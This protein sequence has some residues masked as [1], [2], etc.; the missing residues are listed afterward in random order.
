MD[1]CSFQEVLS[2]AVGPRSEEE[3]FTVQQ[4]ESLLDKVAQTLRCRKVPTG[5]PSF[6]LLIFYTSCFYLHVYPC[7]LFCLQVVSSVAEQMLLR[8]TV[9]LACKLGGYL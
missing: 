3:V 8:C 2:I 7:F 1:E 9:L 5:S 6:V 4:I